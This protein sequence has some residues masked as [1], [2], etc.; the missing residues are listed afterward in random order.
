[1]PGSVAVPREEFPVKLG[2]LRDKCDRRRRKSAH[3]LVIVSESWSLEERMFIPQ[4]RRGIELDF[5]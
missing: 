4:L 1:M 3:S 5:L 2:R